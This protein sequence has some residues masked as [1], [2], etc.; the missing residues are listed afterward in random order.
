MPLASLSS[1]NVR[2]LVRQ[3]V[4]HIDVCPV[5]FTRPSSSRLVTMAMRLLFCCQT[6]SQKSA[7]VAATGPSTVKHASESVTVALCARKTK[8]RR[9]YTAE[10]ARHWT[11]NRFHSVT[12]KCGLRSRK[13]IESGYRVF[14]GMWLPS[15]DGN[16]P[17]LE[18]YDM[19]PKL[20]HSRPDVVK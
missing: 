14:S 8:G 12:L 4:K 10:E 6:I 11:I 7:N 5:R 16:G 17:V 15:M 19:S 3:K 18:T 9:G 20:G 1:D 2:I 13:V